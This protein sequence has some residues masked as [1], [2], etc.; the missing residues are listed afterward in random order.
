MNPYNPYGNPGGPPPSGAYPYSGPYYPPQPYP[1]PAQRPPPT[2]VVEEHH[3]GVGGAIKHAKAKISSNLSFMDQG[4][5]ISNITEKS[6]KRLEKV[7]PCSLKDKVPIRVTNQ[8][9]EEA[10]EDKSWQV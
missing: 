9:L 10:A 6:V 3:E 2:I 7:F 1:P 8:E 5:Q 4:A